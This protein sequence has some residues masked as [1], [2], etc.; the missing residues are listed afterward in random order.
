MLLVRDGKLL[1]GP[2]GCVCP[3]WGLGVWV[4]MHDAFQRDQYMFF[5]FGNI[6]IVVSV[7]VEYTIIGYLDRSVSEGMH[8][9]VF[10]S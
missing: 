9:F 7:W 5:V 4:C 8:Q 2:P 10:T 6:I 1:F 3:F